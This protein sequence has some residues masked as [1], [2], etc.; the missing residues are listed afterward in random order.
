M[1]LGQLDDAVLVQP[2]HHAAH[3]R[4][5]G[6]VQVHDG[7]RRALQ[8]LERPAALRWR[9]VDRACEKSLKPTN[10]DQRTRKEAQ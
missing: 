8:R 6:V 4:R 9:A 10:S 3:H 7:T 2:Q 1:A 5:G